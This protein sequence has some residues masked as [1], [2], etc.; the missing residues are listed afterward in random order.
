MSGRSTIL[1]AYGQTFVQGLRALLPA[2][3]TVFV[4]GALLQLV[5]ARRLEW[6]PISGVGDIRHLV[7]PNGI[8]GT[9]K[10]MRFIA[11]ELSYDTYISLMSQY[12][13][14]YK[15]ESFKEISRRITAEEYDAARTAMDDAGLYNGWVQEGHGLDSFAGIHI[16]P[17]H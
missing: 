10:I 8:S 2:L 13:P 16:K 15:A 11:S 17:K 3:L 1:R 14:C 5:F 9:E 6:F 4:L 7:L 12:F